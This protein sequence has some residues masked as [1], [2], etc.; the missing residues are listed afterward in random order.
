M[1]AMAAAAWEFREVTPVADADSHSVLMV[2]RTPPLL[3]SRS[4][5]A[6]WTARLPDPNDAA[7]F[8]RESYSVAWELDAIFYGELEPWPPSTWT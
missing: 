1:S 5:Y 3:L 7:E 4:D 8:Q 6:G 2:V